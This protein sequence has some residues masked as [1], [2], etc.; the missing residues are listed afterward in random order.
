MKISTM[1]FAVLGLAAA[2]SGAAIAQSGPVA[3]ICSKEIAKYCAKAGHGNA[4]TRNCLEKHRKD[5]SAA[6][7]KALDTTGGGRGRNRR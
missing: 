1:I 2:M 7:R 4:Q 3:T 5:L 6:C